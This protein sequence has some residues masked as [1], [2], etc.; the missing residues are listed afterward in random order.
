MKPVPAS[1]IK[2]HVKGRV[3][4]TSLGIESTDDFSIMFRVLFPVG[5]STPAG[6]R[7]IDPDHFSKLVKLVNAKS[8]IYL[9]ESDDGSGLI[10][11]IGMSVVNMDEEENSKPWPEYPKGVEIPD[12]AGISTV[13]LNELAKAAKAAKA[14]GVVITRRNTCHEFRCFDSDGNEVADGWFMPV[15]WT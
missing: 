13:A 8:D 5:V 3:R 9:T 1:V 6:A 15:I 12:N 2:S 14:S 10:A 11:T 4:F 7:K